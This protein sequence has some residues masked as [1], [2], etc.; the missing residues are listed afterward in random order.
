MAVVKWFVAVA[1]AD[2]RI[3][4]KSAHR[5]LVRALFVRTVQRGGKMVPSP[6][7]YLTPKYRIKCAV[8]PLHVYTQNVESG[9]VRGG[10]ALLVRK[11]AKTFTFFAQRKSTI[12]PRKKET[13]RW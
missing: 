1:L 3:L 8:P 5:N 13:G 12:R 4:R 9:P 10:G 2:V 7:K 11:K 6:S